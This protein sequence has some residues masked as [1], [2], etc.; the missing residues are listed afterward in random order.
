MCYYLLT[1][2]PS[3]PIISGYLEGSII[4]AG[5]IQKLVCISSG[6][7]PLATLNWY[8]ND[9]KVSFFFPSFSQFVIVAAVRAHLYVLSR[10][11]MV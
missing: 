8:K 4:P 2:P 3:A 6:G 10:L 1:D 7:N 9:K 11:S 5:S